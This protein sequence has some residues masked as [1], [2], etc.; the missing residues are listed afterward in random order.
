[1]IVLSASAS[2]DLYIFNADGTEVT[3]EEEELIL[4]KLRERK[5]LLDLFGKRIMDKDNEVYTFEAEIS[6]ADYD[7]SED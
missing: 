5:Y 7:F 2:I 4:E 6:Y 1:M 3:P